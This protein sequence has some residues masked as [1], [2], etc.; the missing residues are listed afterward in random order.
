MNARDFRLSGHCDV[1]HN[2]SLLHSCSWLNLLMPGG[3]YWYLLLQ[4][5]I[6]RTNCDYVSKN[7]P[8]SSHAEVFSGKCVV[9]ICRKFTGEHP[10]Q[11]MISIM[12]LCNFIEITLWHRYSPVNFLHTFW[13]Q[14]T[15][16][17]LLLILGA[18]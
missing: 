18:F 16:G 14:N 2:W 6:M 17:R 10:Y 1:G 11:S 8:K 12:L 7:L 15:S 5:L 13:T 9:K 4:Y 3:N